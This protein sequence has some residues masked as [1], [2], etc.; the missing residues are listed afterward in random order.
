[1]KILFYKMEDDTSVP[2]G[3]H[4]FVGNLDGVFL[5]NYEVIRQLGKGGY[6]KV[7]EVKNIKTGEIRACKH[8]SKLSIKNLEKFERE[9]NILKRTD[10]PHIIKLYEVFQSQRS[11]YLVMQL[12]KGGEVFD[13]IIEHIQNKKMYSE[14]DAANMFRQVMSSIEYCHNNGICHRDLKP[15]NLLYL[16]EGNEKDNPIKVI[17]FGLSQIFINRK[18]KTKVGTAYYVA[19]EILE[20]NY[21]EKC[22][23]WSAG[24]IL[25]IFLSGDPP[26][27]GPNDTAIYN[28]IVQMK[29][30][31]PE[32]K[33]KNVSNEAKDLISHMIAP[34]KERY[35][36][37]Q[38][39][40]HPWFKNAS[41][42]PLTDL[43]F[44]PALLSN[45]SHDKPLK[46]AILLFIASRLDE[47]EILHLKQI[48]EAFDESKDG[49][50]SYDELNKGLAQLKSSNLSDK[51]IFEMFKGID[52][53]KN[54]RIDYTEFIAAT[55]EEKTYLKKERLFEAFCIFDKDNTGHISKENIIQ[56]LK[57]EKWQEKEIEKY[58]KSADKN[59]D[60]VID[61]KEFLEFMG[62]DKDK[63]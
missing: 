44:D 53:D 60:G 14:K 23:V 43:E 4:I 27:N 24:V 29:F 39:L 8:L 50:I 9:I 55:L 17:D 18:L 47:N 7:Y 37:Q 34:E 36:A 51:S 49:Q 16:N 40:S 41:N 48:F 3:K 11:L 12:C 45:Y 57:A 22:D 1:M 28:K 20:G 63:L 13:R 25:Y 2:F 6:G 5:D 31:F 62:Y 46:K 52:V 59:G 30:S 33:W 26:F 38:V 19:P 35:N 58:I 21:T 42:T 15:E 10:H 56:V 32:K 54:G 61:Y